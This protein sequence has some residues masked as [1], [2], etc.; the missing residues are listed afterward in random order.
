MAWGNMIDSLQFMIAGIVSTKI[1]WSMHQSTKE[2]VFMSP[3]K[4]VILILLNVLLVFSLM[5][6]NRL[7]EPV[8]L[9]IEPNSAPN[10]FDSN[11]VILGSGFVDSP[12]VYLGETLL[13]EITWVSEDQ[14]E[15]TVPWGLAPGDY[16]LSVENPDGGLAS[17]PNAFTVE[18][19]LNIWQSGEINGGRVQEIAVAYKDNDTRTMYVAARDVGLFRSRDDGLNWDYIYSSEK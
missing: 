4:F 17:L 3:S 13:E 2:G 8:I 12:A 14:L 7:D 6:S 1:S 16:T 11:V 19:G 15:A 18:P 5:G 10:D 9:S